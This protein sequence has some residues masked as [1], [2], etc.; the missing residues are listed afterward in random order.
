MVIGL[1]G[2]GPLNPW[3]QGWLLAGPLGPDPVQLWLGWTYF[4]SGPWELPPG[5]NPAYGL[6]LGTAIYFADAIPLLALLLKAVR[7]FVDIPQYVGPWL[8]VCGV[9]Q[10]VVGWRLIGLVTRDPLARVCGAGLMLLQPMLVNRMA[11]HTPLAGQWTI[12]AALYLTCTPTHGRRTTLAWVALLGVTSLI[13]AYLLAMVLPLWAADWLRRAKT[14]GALIELVAAPLAVALALWCAGFFLLRGGYASG[15][16]HESG[17][18]GSWN[19]DL[20]A[21]ADGGAWSALLPDLPDPGHWEAG[22]SYLGLGALLLIAL[23]LVALARR[24][25]GV[26]QRLWP[27][28]AVL[29][30]LLAFAV[31]PHITIGGRGTTLFTR[32]TGCFRSVGHCAIPSG[33]SGHSPMP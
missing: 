29:V 24:P 5:A 27:L 13:H 26:P 33:W 23:G 19:F 15:P 2:P 3:N 31:T 1:F 6:E 17:R 14:R 21:F 25:T 12:L 10:A 16:G 32:R 20:L 18:Y 7:G 22:S 4:R 8:L 28:L 11:G 9:L 30:A